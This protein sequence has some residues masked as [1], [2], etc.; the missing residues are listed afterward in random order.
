MVNPFSTKFW[1]D[2]AIPFQ[3]AQ[4]S[5]S[6]E[7]LLE[8][9]RRYSLCQIIGPHGTGK[10]TLLL[11]ICRRYEASGEKVRHLFFNDQQRRL[12][13]DVVLRKDLTFF[14]DGF[15]QLPTL[16]QL[17][18]CLGATRLIVTT[19][20]PLWFVPILYRTQPQFS[21]FV[22][23][24]GQMVPNPPE[25]SVLRAVYDRAGGNVRTAFF[26]LYDIYAESNVDNSDIFSPSSP[27]H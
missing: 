11:A 13:D 4:P 23:I 22:Q 15:E 25:E 17:W 20:H 6:M 14:V 21:V 27:Q 16:S 10:T 24:V 26:E 18:L 19:H 5:E 9:A 8:R 12:P 3:F 7:V 1:A 2:G